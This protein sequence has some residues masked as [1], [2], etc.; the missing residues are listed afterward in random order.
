MKRVWR[1]GLF[2]LGLALVLFY[3][4]GGLDAYRWAR[5]RIRVAL[6]P[7]T[8]A[9]LARTTPEPPPPLRAALPPEAVRGRM[10][11]SD[12][13]KPTSIAIVLSSIVLCTIG[14]MYVTGRPPRRG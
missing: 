13:P 12:P 8:A 14:A 9:Q 11:L 5:M 4:V 3:I 2:Y 1:R 10:W 7:P 6:Q